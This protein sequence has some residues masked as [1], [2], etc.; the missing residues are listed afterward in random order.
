MNRREEFEKDLAAFKRRYPMVVLK[1][2]TPDDFSDMDSTLPA[3][4]DAP[5]MR[6]IRDTVD[7]NYDLENGTGFKEIASMIPDAVLQV[8]EEPS[9]ASSRLDA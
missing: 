9:E 2:V 1:A 3:D 6:S 4:W 8:D 5:V 7:T